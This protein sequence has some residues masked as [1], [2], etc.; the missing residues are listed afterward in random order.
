MRLKDLIV[1]EALLE[2]EFAVAL[3]FEVKHQASLGLWVLASCCPL[4][5]PTI[6]I[7]DRSDV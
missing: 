3:L 5:L 1:K 4:Y 7:Q 2:L 6:F